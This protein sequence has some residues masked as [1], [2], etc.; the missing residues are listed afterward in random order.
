MI[1]AIY[2]FTD[3]SEKRPVYCA[4]QLEELKTFANS[5]DIDIQEIYL[6]KSL[7]VSEQVEF[8]RFL[9]EADR[10]D[11]LV[12]KDFYHLSKNTMQCIRIMKGLRERGISI[13][14]IENGT[15]CFE[16]VPL[17]KK[18]RVASYT[19]GNA[20]IKNIENYINVQN[21]IYSLFVK[22]KT[23]WEMVTHFL[24]VCDLQNDSEQEE[25][26]K[27]IDRKD[28]FDIL[29]VNNLNDLHWRTSKFCKIREQLGKDI[30][31]LQDGYLKYRKE[32]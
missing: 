31:S 19:Y 10:Y 20:N 2:H 6:D 22:K 29:I 4:K 21:D 13:Y 3:K 11:A 30:Y 27:M 8:Q 9:N 23:N 25:L 1:G 15:F 24:D 26:R 32:A 14:S 5:K 12:T 7:V 28:E 17:D 18:L 16:E